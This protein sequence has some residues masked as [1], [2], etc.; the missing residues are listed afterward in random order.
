MSTVDHTA[1]ISNIMSHSMKEKTFGKPTSESMNIEIEKLDLNKISGL[2][3]IFEED[4]ETPMSRVSEFVPYEK[5][6]LKTKKLTHLNPDK[7]RWKSVTNLSNSNYNI[8]RDG[9]LINIQIKKKHKNQ[10]ATYDSKKSELLNNLRYV[11]SIRFSVLPTWVMEFS[12]NNKY[13]ATGGQDCILRIW[14]IN[15]LEDD[16]EYLSFINPEPF[17]EYNTHKKDIVDISW[18]TVNKN[19]LLTASHDMKIILWRIDHDRPLQIYTHQDLVTSVSFKPGT[20]IFATCSIDKI[21]RLWSIEH[22]RVVNW[23]EAESVVTAIEFSTDG[24]RLV[25][26]SMN[27]QWYVFDTNKSNLVHLSNIS[28]K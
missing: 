9:E 7:R 16:E 23:Y 28:C 27:G 10:T 22:K 12:K 17:R 5:P 13:L 19:L 18:N 21:I 25:A 24:E 1:S 15:Y 4:K 6:I 14:E 8:E 11:Q 20:N 26:G 3:P 2:S